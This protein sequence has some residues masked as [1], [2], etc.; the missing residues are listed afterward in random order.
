MTAH[1]QHEQTKNEY[2]ELVNRKKELETA[3]NANVNDQEALTALRAD[4]RKVIDQMEKI[5]TD[6]INYFGDGKVL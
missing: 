5:Y 1:T 4:Y 3:I 2:L 6:N